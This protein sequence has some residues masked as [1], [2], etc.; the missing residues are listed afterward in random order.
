MKARVLAILDWY[1]KKM[2]S[3]TNSARRAGILLV[4]ERALLIG[5][6]LLVM[7]WAG[8]TLW[9]NLASRSEVAELQR[10]LAIPDQALWS[11]ARKKAYLESLQSDPGSAVALLR[12]D[13]LNI[14]TPVFDA[15]SEL[16][17]N[18]GVSRIEGTATLSEKDN[19][20]IAGHRDSFF[21]PLKD[22]ET[23]DEIV[24]QSPLGEV[25]YRVVETLIVDPE[26]IWVLDPTEEAMLTL[27]TCYP[28]YF[29]GN[30]PER[31][32]VRAVADTQTTGP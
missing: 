30:A 24:L 3:S 29:V 23:G 10:S 9:G 6:V 15:V 4:L 2:D 31:F 5:G 27:V 28:F 22:I 32:I 11:A 1:Y 18:R 7:I 26:D 21:R 25:S 8:V 12:I 19:L 14:E 17:L 13:R 16:N 20:G